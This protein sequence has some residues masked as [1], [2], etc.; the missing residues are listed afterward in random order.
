[1]ENCSKDQ[2]C[3]KLRGV[4]LEA[5]AEHVGLTPS[6][7]SAV[8]NNS[9]AARAM[10]ERTKKRV[11]AAARE[12]NYRPNSL[13]RSSRVQRTCT[14]GIITRDLGDAH[15]R[16]PVMPVY[17]WQKGEF[18][19]TTDQ[20]RLDLDVIHEYLAQQSYWARGVPR[21]TLE[22]SVRNSLCFGLCEGNRQI[23]FAR[24][25]SD[26]ATIAYLGDFF[27]S[28]QYRGRGL[29]KWLMECVTAH[30]DLQNLRRWILVTKDAHALYRRYGFTQLAR[31]ESFMERYDPDVYDGQNR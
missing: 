17:E 13:A 1:M 22:K 4:T 2:D 21:L 11:L 3:P 27:V 30:P 23:G 12:L 28:P 15:I 24:V 19:I 18:E 16:R 20:A 25:I 7:V 26:Y 6:T 5:V 29:A 31:H 14:I 8:L 9:A 10:P